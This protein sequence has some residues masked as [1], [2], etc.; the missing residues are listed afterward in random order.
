MPG[1]GRDAPEGEAG[2]TIHKDP[3]RNLGTGSLRVSAERPG[4]AG[5]Q[6]VTGT[7]TCQ[8][9][10]AAV[11]RGEVAPTRGNLYTHEHVVEWGK[12]AK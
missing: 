3:C 12:D 1:P 5:S 11:R 8:D 2:A 6:G 10:R 4:R 9:R 7:N